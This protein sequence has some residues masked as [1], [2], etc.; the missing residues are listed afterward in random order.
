L[1]TGTTIPG[2]Q[3][4]AWADP[5]E[6][7]FEPGRLAAFADRLRTPL[8][9]SFM[10]VAGGR[11]VLRHGDV[12]EASYLASTRKS[13]L[14]M[15]YGPHV[16]S[17]RIDLDR[18]LEDLGI[19]DVQGL[20]PAERRARIRD[21]LASR[22][23]IYY[24]AGSPGGDDET[25]P[26][27]S[28]PPGARF[29][30]NNWDF[31]VA[32]AIFAQLTGTEVH[33]ALERDLAGPLGFEDFDRSRQRMLGYPDRSRF[34]AYHMFLS[35]RD[36]ARVGLLACRLGRW[37]G[38]QLIPE[39]WMRESTRMHVAPEKLGRRFGDRGMGYGYCWWLPTKPGNA[40]WEG[41]FMASG[42]FGQFILCLPRLDI[43]MVHRRAI[44][45]DRAERRNA[46]IEVGDL[47]SVSASG[48]IGLADEALQARRPA[49]S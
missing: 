15:L 49:A 4:D 35:C 41:A 8:T 27:G 16:A 18:T 6:A 48:M 14:S 47:P 23:G 2:A 25:P 46:G 26:R 7:G 3:W 32:G 28:V 19:D 30:Y 31:N 45:D 29:H 33:D 5:R 42:H 37:G 24:P 43:V 21:I 22:S 13:I 20:L 44:S 38:R 34:L 36:M 9:T 39:T 11:V 1:D 12:G 17:G 10:I 40:D